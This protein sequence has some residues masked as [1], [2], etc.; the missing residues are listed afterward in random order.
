[1]SSIDSRSRSARSASDCIS[2]ERIDAARDWSIISQNLPSS[3]RSLLVRTSRRAVTQTAGKRL[4]CG[5]FYAGA[6]LARYFD[7]EADATRERPIADVGEVEALLVDLAGM[8]S[9]SGRGMPALELARDDGSALAI[10]PTPY[11][12][13]LM[14]TDPLEHNFH[15]IGDRS[16][17]GTVVFDYFGSYTEVPMDSVV[18]REVTL[19]AAYAYLVVGSPDTGELLF[20][21][22]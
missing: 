11:G 4:N 5:V 1:M 15:S 17:E 2:P 12:D 18:P 3:T 13:V 6:M 7:P 16:S 22:D 9:G 10:G 14:W 20:E 21:P 19:R 8:G